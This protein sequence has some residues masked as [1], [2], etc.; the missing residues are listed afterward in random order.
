MLCV[1]VW[2]WLSCVMGAVLAL[3][4]GGV[5]LWWCLVCVPCLLAAVVVHGWVAYVVG[6]APCASGARLV[7]VFAARVVVVCRLCCG[8]LICFALL[9]R[10]L[11]YAVLPLYARAPLVCI[12]LHCSSVCLRQLY[13]P[14][15]CAVLC[16]SGVCCAALFRCAPL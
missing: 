15:R 2:P 12:A 14:G 1:F 3:G 11:R 10:V 9:R 4:C 8:V 7:S 5:G 16:Y 6:L 13:V